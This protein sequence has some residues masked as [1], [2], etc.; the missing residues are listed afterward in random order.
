M[1][2]PPEPLNELLP[3]SSLIVVA[4]V[5]AVLSVGSKPPAPEGAE[6]LEKGSTSV[7]QKAAA[8]K[9][10]LKIE[11]TL[12]GKAT[13]AEIEVEKPVG[14]YLL[15]VGNKGPFFIDDKGVIIGRYGPDTHRAEDIV[16]ALPSK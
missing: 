5:V 2:L 10:R 1:A 9:V 16:R 12:K 3:R 7:G 15:D 4:V 14:A 6:K 11:R 8:Q 13:A